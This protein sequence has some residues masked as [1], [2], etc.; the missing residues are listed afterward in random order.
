M[1]PSR[2][3]SVSLET[4][5]GMFLRM[6]SPLISGGLFFSLR[7]SAPVRHCLL[8]LVRVVDWFVSRLVGLIC[9]RIILTQAVQGGY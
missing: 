8:L 9:C 7:C 1:K 3:P 6:S 4:E 5:T 2:R